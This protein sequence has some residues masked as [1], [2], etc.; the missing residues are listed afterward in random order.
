[1]STKKRIRDTETEYG[2]LRAAAQ[3]LQKF[4]LTAKAAKVI[5]QM[6]AAASICQL[7]PRPDP[8]LFLSVD[9]KAGFGFIFVS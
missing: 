2:N 8:A 1:M 5:L 7:I 3:T 9:P 6:S 4:T